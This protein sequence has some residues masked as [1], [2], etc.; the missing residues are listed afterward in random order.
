MQFWSAHWFVEMHW[1][2]FRQSSLFSQAPLSAQQL[3][4]RHESHDAF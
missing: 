1:K 2:I 3:F 4:L